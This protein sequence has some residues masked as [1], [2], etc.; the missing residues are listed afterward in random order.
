[1]YAF[2]TFSCKQS[3]IK[4][5]TLD[6]EMLSED[7]IVRY[8]FGDFP[9]ELIPT[10][11]ISKFEPVFSLPSEFEKIAN[12]YKYI[13]TLNTATKYVKDKKKLWDMISDSESKIKELK[14]ITNNFPIEEYLKL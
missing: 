14:K 4:V 3:L 10:N 13:A 2:K 12:L 7:Y 8:I 9:T 11:I 1:M 6:S 5:F